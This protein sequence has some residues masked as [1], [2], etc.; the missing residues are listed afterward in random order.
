MTLIVPS[1]STAIRGLYGQ[2]KALLAGVLG[3]RYRSFGRRLEPVDD[4]MVAYG[5]AGA[6]WV[7]ASKLVRELFDCTIVPWEAL[8]HS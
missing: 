5:E 7:K 4:V 1:L 6:R 2:L 8:C 3:V